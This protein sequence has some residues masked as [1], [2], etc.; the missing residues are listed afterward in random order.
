MG[1]IYK[2]SGLALLVVLVF[3]CATEKKDQQETAASD[4]TRTS[5]LDNDYAE[6]VKV[7]L[8]PGDAQEAHEGKDRLIY[9]L[10]DYSIEWMEKGEDLGVKEWKEGMIHYHVAGMHAAKNNGDTN[11]EWLV[12]VRKDSALPECGD[13]TLENDVTSV[14]EERTEVLFEN[15]LFKATK[16]V[17]PAGEKLPMHSGINRVI[18]SLSDYMVEY[19]SDKEGEIEKSFSAGDVHWHEACMHSMENIGEND[20][21][22]LVVAYKK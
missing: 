15:E 1:N 22:L 9:S 11:A 16:V 18:Y 21:E 17:L 6:V 3:G 8:Q 2:I 7:V 14:A 5:I 13:N 20:A 4:N 10:N 19:E 12:F